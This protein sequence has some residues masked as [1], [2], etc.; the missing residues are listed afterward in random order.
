MG[1]TDKNQLALIVESGNIVIVIASEVCDIRV[2]AVVIRIGLNIN[3][4]GFSRNADKR[5][6][7]KIVPDG[8]NRI[9]GVDSEI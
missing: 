8:D 4:A 9:P 1:M 3:C 6:G 2:N 7:F 5:I